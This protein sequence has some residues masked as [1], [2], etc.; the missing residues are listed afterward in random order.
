MTNHAKTGILY[1]VNEKPLFWVGST[2]EVVRSF[3]K[4]VRGVVGFALYQAQKGDKHVQVKPLRG[5]GGSTV[6]EIV[7][8]HDRSTY[9]AVYTVRFKGAVYALHA[10][11]KKSKKGIRTPKQEIELIRERL[12]RAAKHYAKLSKGK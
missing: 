11:Q 1:A 10:F 12:R 5:F 2:L 8:D 4:D 9:R 7:E 3:P 6:L